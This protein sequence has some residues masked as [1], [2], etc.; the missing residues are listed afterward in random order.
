MTDSG[1]PGVLVRTRLRPGLQ[2]RTGMCPHHGGINHAMLHV[3][4]IGK[5]LKHPLP[6]ICV[7]PAS[8]LLVHAVPVPVPL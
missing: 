3:G 4:I 1:Q 8:K 2:R 6:H 5:M 7:A